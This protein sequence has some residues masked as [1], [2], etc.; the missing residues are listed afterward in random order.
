MKRLIAAALALTAGLGIAG[1]FAQQ[2][3]TTI[4]AH[5]ANAK[6]AA[7]FDFAGTLARICVAPQTAP[8]AD[9]PPPPMT[10]CTVPLV[11]SM[12]SLRVSTGIGVRVS[13]PSVPRSGC[14]RS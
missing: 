13:V 1:A 3:A 12:S 14:D 2:A 11:E 7:G 5:L 9:V 8:G 10:R 4:E 6:A